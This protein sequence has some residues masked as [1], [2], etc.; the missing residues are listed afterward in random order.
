MVHQNP[1]LAAGVLLGTEE[2][3]GIAVG[4]P[5]VGVVGRD[6]SGVACRQVYQGS[7]V[8]VIAPRSTI[9]PSKVGKET[10]WASAEHA[11]SAS[12][13]STQVRV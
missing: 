4:K 10:V 7:G 5:G 6:R 9:S 1:L 3:V 11:V 13:P 12:T 2:L 8:R